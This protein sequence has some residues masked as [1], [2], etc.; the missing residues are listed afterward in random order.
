[1]P[2]KTVSVFIEPEHYSSPLREELER[3][4]EKYDN[5]ET[6]EA[7]EEKYFKYCGDLD[8]TVR[9]SYDSIGYDY[10]SISSSHEIIEVDEVEFEH[11]DL[12]NDDGI[13]H[14]YRES[15]GYCE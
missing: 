13:D 1:M 4:G 3:L 11:F 8:V 15:E 5:G 9:W 14:I 12:L 7:E 6:T 2:K 10:G